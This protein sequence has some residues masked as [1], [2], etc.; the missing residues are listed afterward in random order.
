MD[1]TLTVIEP[2]DILCTTQQD[3]LVPLNQLHQYYS[4]YT[5]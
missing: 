1:V 2:S 5:N 4:K 3:V